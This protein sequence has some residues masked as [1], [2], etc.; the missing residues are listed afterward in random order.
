[1]SESPNQNFNHLKIHTQN[2]E[3]EGEVKMYNLQDFTKLNM[4]KA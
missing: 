2:S 1:M 4:I 3:C